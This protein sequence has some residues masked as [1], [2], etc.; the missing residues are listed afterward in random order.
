MDQNADFFTPVDTMAFHFF[1][2][3]AMPLA[4][5]FDAHKLPKGAPSPQ[6]EGLP[7]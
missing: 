2:I 7:C 5:P 4:N 6:Q 1:E 3:Y